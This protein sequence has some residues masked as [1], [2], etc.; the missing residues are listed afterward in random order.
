MGKGGS[1]LL[2]RAP[3]RTSR[4]LAKCSPRAAAL[5]MVRRR[6]TWS[7]TQR[8][9][10]PQVHLTEGVVP[11]AQVMGAVHGSDGGGFAGEAQARPPL[12]ATNCTFTENRSPSP[13]AALAAGI[14]SG[15]GTTPEV[16]E[17]VPVVVP[18]GDAVKRPAVP[19]DV[20]S[21]LN[22]VVVDNPEVVAV[23]PLRAGGV[24]TLLPEVTAACVSLRLIRLR[25]A[26]RHD[27]AEC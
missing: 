8:S 18:H 24:T 7:S 27:D 14:V 2:S 21:C 16:P 26:P 20:H 9:T 23:V 17:H 3:R 1:A 11:D 5:E 25:D 12:S 6:S 4:A 22:V 15:I 10:A 19:T 13:S